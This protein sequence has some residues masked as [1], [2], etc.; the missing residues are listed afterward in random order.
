MVRFN[1]S[2]SD[3]Y[4]LS[5]SRRE[6]SLTRGWVCNC[7]CYYANWLQS[8]RTHKTHN[9][10]LLSRLRLLQPGGTIPCIYIPQEQGGPVISQSI[11]FTCIFKLKLYCDPRSV[12]QF[13]L[14][15]GPLW[16]PWPDLNFLCL[17]ITFFL[18]HER[19]HLW[20]EDGSVICSAITH[21]L[22]SRKTHNHILLSHL[23]LLQ[24]GRPG[25]LTHISH[26]EG[27]P[28]QSQSQKSKSH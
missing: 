17:T 9:H 21:R 4:F 15:S 20:Q 12:D 8:R 22:E 2:L 1:I 19:Y 14:V 28:A 7:Q 6:P 3:N 13:V 26:E 23:R 5:S 11:S 10:I 16:D 18:L 25:P 24:S 27:G